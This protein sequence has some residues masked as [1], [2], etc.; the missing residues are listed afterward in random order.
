MTAGGSTRA[1]GGSGGAMIGEDSTGQSGGQTVD[2]HL[3]CNTGM[4]TPIC[5]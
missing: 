1:G 5:K 2:R 4:I 3:F